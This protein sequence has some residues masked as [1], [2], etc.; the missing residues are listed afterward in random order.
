MNVYKILAMKQPCA[1]TLQEISFAHVLMVWSEIQFVAVAAN[2]VN[3]S[4]T[5]IVPTLLYAKTQNVETL[6]SLQKLVVR[7]RSAELLVI[8]F[9]VNV[10]Q[11]QR[12][13]LKLHVISS[14]VLKTMNAT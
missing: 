8:Q 3:V 2:L 7:M 11:E 4:L 5:L 14:N 6:A 1:K 13:I 12:E 10:L 9:H